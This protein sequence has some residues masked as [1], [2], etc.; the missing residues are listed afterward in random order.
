MIQ[1]VQSIWLFLASLTLFLLLILPIFTKQGTSGDLS[2]QIGGIYQ[3]TNNVSHKTES[4][5]ALFGGTILVGLICLANI[6][7]FKNRSLQ[8]NIILLTILLII[9]LAGW[10]ASYAFNIPGGFDGAVFG[11]GAGLP[12]FSILFCVLAIRGIRKDEQLIRSADRLR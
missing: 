6:F 3:K 4:F 11:V 9:A 7:T 12:I 5:T 1:R 10:T 8:K 2:F